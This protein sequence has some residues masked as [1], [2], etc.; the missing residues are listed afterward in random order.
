MI[1]RAIN[2]IVV[3]N[4]ILTDFLENYAKQIEQNGLFEKGVLNA[5]ISYAK[6]VSESNKEQQNKILNNLH[7]SSNPLTYNTRYI[8]EDLK[9]F[10]E[11]LTNVLIVKKW[12]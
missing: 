5:F 7:Q 4:C 2:K 11:H 10:S 6:A 8:K 1:T 12:W 3:F 9:S